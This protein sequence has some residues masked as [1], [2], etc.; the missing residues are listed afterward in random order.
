MNIH[1]L[2]VF[3]AKWIQG[4]GELSNRLSSPIVRHV[5]FSSE[6]LQM[7]VDVLQLFY[8]LTAFVLVLHSYTY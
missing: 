3:S 2:F 5:L 7:K 8:G 6:R 4:Q 1:Y